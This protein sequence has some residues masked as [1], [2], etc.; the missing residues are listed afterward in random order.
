ML[1]AMKSPVTPMVESHGHSPKRHVSTR[2]SQSAPKIRMTM[3]TSKH[4]T[5]HTGMN[6]PAQN[7]R[8]PH[9]MPCYRTAHVLIVKIGLAKRTPSGGSKKSSRSVSF[10]MMASVRM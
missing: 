7:K 2:I 4:A 10:H 5:I 9:A 3:P 1:P 8:H 6:C